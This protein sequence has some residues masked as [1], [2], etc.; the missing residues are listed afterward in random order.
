MKE[1]T[2]QLSPFEFST[3][4]LSHHT[5]MT[6]KNHLEIPTKQSR[7]TPGK[8]GPDITA[9]SLQTSTV[10][11][12]KKPLIVDKRWGL[13]YWLNYPSLL[14]FSWRRRSTKAKANRLKVTVVRVSQRNV[15]AWARG[16]RTHHPHRAGAAVQ[17]RACRPHTARAARC[18]P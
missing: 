9:Y 7:R 12:P 16:K 17:Q 6:E 1:T 14:F 15:H 13:D 5:S 3:S 10:T 11:T 8:R 4:Q 2:H 18:R